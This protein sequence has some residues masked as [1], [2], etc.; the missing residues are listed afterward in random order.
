MNESHLPAWA[1]ERLQRFIDAHLHRRL[2]IAELASS[3]GYS[4]SYFFRTFKAT[5]GSTPHA[6]VLMRRLE[7]ACELMLGT[8]DALCDIAVRCGLADQAHFTRRFRQA[9]D[10]P[11]GQWRRR[12]RAADTVTYSP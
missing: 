12:E 10:A 9:F 4:E 6:Y 3:I 5:F 7:R 2:A 8:D 1:R 11:P